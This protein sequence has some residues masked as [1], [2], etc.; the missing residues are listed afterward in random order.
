MA[1]T[2]RD[3]RAPLCHGGVVGSTSNSAVIRQQA[4]GRP[5]RVLTWNLQ[6]SHGV[7]VAAVTAVVRAARVDVIALQEVQRA[8]ARHIAAALSITSR[9]WVLKHW[10]I[11]QRAEGLAVLTPHRVVR[12]SRFL[13]RRTWIWTWRRRVGIDVTMAT[14]AGLVRVIDVHLS[15]HDHRGHRRREVALVAARAR[16]PGPRPI[17]VG[18]LNELPGGGALDALVTA[19]WLDAWAVVHGEADGGATN[20]TGGSRAGR[21][22]T[23]RLDY[24]LVPPGSSVVSAL[25]VDTAEAVDHVDEMGSL[26]DHLPLVVEVVVGTTS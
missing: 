11:V 25:V 21:P 7:D 18:D 22:A 5:V 14:D 24:V 26:S 2:V 6:G 10:P 12:S 13:L 19:G 16:R 20:W 23:Q 3:E 17:V 15:P 4:P 8:Q 9:R 1:S